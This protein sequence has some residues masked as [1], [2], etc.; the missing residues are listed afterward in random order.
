MNKN[1]K[2]NKSIEPLTAWVGGKS[3]EMHMIKKHMPKNF[4]RYCEPFFG[5]G[6]VYWRLGIDVPSVLN[7]YNPHLISLYRSVQRGDAKKIK[8]FL[9][10]MPCGKTTFNII[11]NTPPN[12]DI[13][14]ARR[15]A[16]V[17]YYSAS[18][19]YSFD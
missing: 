5:G 11:R 12:S 14:R 9:E 6:A 17:V 7:D 15:L 1:S 18:L 2:N 8:T 3:K 10:R 16:Y 4:N 19:S 13:S